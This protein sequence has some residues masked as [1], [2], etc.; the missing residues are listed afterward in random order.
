MV[1]LTKNCQCFLFFLIRIVHLIL[2]DPWGFVE[3]PLKVKDQS[4]V[5][6]AQA[7]I[8][9]TFRQIFRPFNPL[10]FLRAAGPFG[11][12][13]IHYFRQDLRGF[14]D[15]RPI[16]VEEVRYVFDKFCYLNSCCCLLE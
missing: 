12:S 7:W 16:R 15:Q 3:D 10:S 9:S 13:L 11:P 14:F 5:G 2:A 1:L 8:F 6:A 4:N